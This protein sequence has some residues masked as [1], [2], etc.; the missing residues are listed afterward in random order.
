MADCALICTMPNMPAGAQFTGSREDCLTQ[1]AQLQFGTNH[2]RARWQ[3]RVEA[4]W[5]GETKVVVRDYITRALKWTW[6]IVDL[7]VAIPLGV[8][9]SASPETT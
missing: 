3:D 1:L 5:R 7:R 4:E 2:D 6:E 9:P 8:T